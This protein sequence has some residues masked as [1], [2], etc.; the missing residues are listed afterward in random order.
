[1]GSWGLLKIVYCVV[2]IIFSKHQY[3]GDK[4]QNFFSEVSG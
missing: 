3:F 1:M 4:G 2:K